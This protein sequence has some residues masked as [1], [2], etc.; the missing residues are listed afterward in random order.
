MNSP[1]QDRMTPAER[2]AGAALA[3]IFALRMLGL[4]LLLPVFSVF[5]KTLPGGDNIFWVGLAFG[6]F[7]LAQACMQ[8]PFGMASD[9]FGRKPV[10]VFGLLLY[11]A[12][13]LMAMWAPDI[14][15]MTVARAL[16]GLGA[17]SAA[18]TALAAD[19]V[20]EQHRTKVMAMIG[21][22]IGLVFAASLVIAPALYAAI[23]MDG[24]FL[25]IAGLALIAI[26]LLLKGV[27]DPV[28]PPVVQPPPPL[29]KVLADGQLMRLNFGVFSVH[30]VQMA[31]F[32]MVPRLLVEHVGTPVAEH[33]KIYLPVVL[34][35]FVLMVP[36]I[37]WSEKRAR[38]RSL[39][40]AAIAAMGAS[41][42]FFLASGD[43]LITIAAGLFV[44]FTAFNLLEASLPSLVSRIAPP[45]A[46]GAALGAFNTSQAI[47]AALG[48]SAGGAIALRFGAPGVFMF[49]T[50]IAAIWWLWARTMKSPPVVAL[51]E[52]SIGDH[53]DLDTLRSRLVELP[54]VREASV[55]AERR[56]AYVKVNLELWDE[57][58]VR[59][60]LDVPATS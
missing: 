11:A 57:D 40:L 60:L 4:F 23:G 53:V 52:Y 30:L 1:I 56:M 20:R 2:R 10:I 28:A 35:S 42:L 7:G 14:G 54:G 29:G 6:I 9:R 46:K 31:M 3:A 36:A 16:Q 8:I 59:R 51:R 13:S 21:S 58:G 41:Q 34:A 12:G 25:T 37:I 44:F 50:A 43:T 27:P 18:V 32:L 19:L 47:G 49:C 24:M 39:L 22:T 26:P 17:I 5:A 48:S 15:W 55:E 38:H 45:S 33:W